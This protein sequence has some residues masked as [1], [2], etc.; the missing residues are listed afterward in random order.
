MLPARWPR[1]EDLEG[2]AGPSISNCALY[3]PKSIQVKTALWKLKFASPVIYA[4][5]CSLKWDMPVPTPSIGNLHVWLL[6]GQA[7][8]F[9]MEGNSPAF[10]STHVLSPLPTISSVFDMSQ[11]TPSLVDVGKQSN[12]TDSPVQICGMWLKTLA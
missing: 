2:F 11:F 1:W 3:Q 5:N 7:M 6:S 12:N 4:S 8:A 9:I 10:L